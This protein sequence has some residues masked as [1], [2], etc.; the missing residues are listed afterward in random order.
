MGNHKS[1][2]KLSERERQENEKDTLFEKSIFCQ[3]IQFL[4]NPKFFTTIFFV[5]SK[6]STAKKSKTTT[7]SRVFQPKKKSTIFSGNQ[8]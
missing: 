3:K 4:Q 8:S 1:R 5:E 7:F 2:G 6:L